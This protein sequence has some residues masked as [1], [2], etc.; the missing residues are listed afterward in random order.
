MIQVYLSFIGNTHYFGRIMNMK[1][2]QIIHITLLITTL[3]IHASD[4]R[5]LS[6]LTNTRPRNFS[7]DSTSS[8]VFSSEGSSTTGLNLQLPAYSSAQD[9]TKI[10]SEQKNSA[11]S[12]T[13]L[14]KNLIPVKLAAAGA[15]IGG[16]LIHEGLKTTMRSPS[17]SWVETI[18]KYGTA[19]AITYWL[20]GDEIKT[21][22]T[23]KKDM[24]IYYER[25]KA[26]EK[27]LGP[28]Q[29]NQQ[30]LED[31]IKQYDAVIAACQ[32]SVEKIQNNDTKLLRQQTG[33]IES[34]KDI[35]R[36]FNAYNTMRAEMG[37]TSLFRQQQNPTVQTPTIPEDQEEEKEEE[38]ISHNA[39][40]QNT[41]LEQSPSLDKLAEHARQLQD[42]LH[43]TLFALVKKPTISQKNKKPRRT[44][45]SSFDP[46]HISGTTL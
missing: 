14:L 27:A 20:I 40:Q 1:L 34:L 28:V 30:K 38:P 18:I 6:S 44:S 13:S 3:R 41:F 9:F 24:N 37:K 2:T 29:S 16:L 32:E 45:S 19:G 4:N 25:L 39:D 22:I 17:A 10:I 35:Q 31:Q 33:L 42:H 8:D 46:S 21:V 23:F 36:N 7:I 12:Y 43:S 26:I 11:P 5:L 15:G